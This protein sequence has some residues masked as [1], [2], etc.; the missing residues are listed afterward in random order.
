MKPQGWQQ[1]R[2]I[3]GNA[4]SVTLVKTRAQWWQQ[5]Q[6]KVCNGIH[7]MAKMH[8][9]ATRMTMPLQQWQ[10]QRHRRQRDDGRD[11]SGDAHVIPNTPVQQCI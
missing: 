4:A 5:C 1:H 8:T 6:H 10:L 7:L 11:I 9:I 3:E 2:C